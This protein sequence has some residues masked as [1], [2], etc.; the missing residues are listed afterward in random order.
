MNMQFIQNRIHTGKSKTFDEMVSNFLKAKEEDSIKTASAKAIVKVAEA[1]EADSSGQLDVEPLH[2]VGESTNQDS[3]NKDDTS[4]ATVKKTVEKDEAEDSGQPKAEKKLENTPKV[5]ASTEVE[6]KLAESEDEEVDVEAKKD[7][8][9]GCEKEEKEEEK[10]AS[11]KTGYI[12]I[13]NLNE[14]SKN[15]LKEYWKNI[16]PAD[17]VDAMLADK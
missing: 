8:D 13:A 1:E 6:T 5:E 11:V 16:Y 17:F 3:I 15:R 7:E 2:Q 14:K 4:K 9:C 12:K 10:E